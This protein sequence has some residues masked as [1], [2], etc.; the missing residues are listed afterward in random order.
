MRSILGGLVVV[1][2]LCAM[3]TTSGC[4]SSGSSDA[5]GFFGLFGSLF[6]GGSSSGAGDTISSIASSASES[7]LSSG[8]GLTTDALH[9]VPNVATVHNPEPASLMLFGGGLV[10]TALWRRRKTRKQRSARG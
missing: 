5:G 9:S 10:G 4:G 8:A 7:G 3:L 6:G 2:G 1:V